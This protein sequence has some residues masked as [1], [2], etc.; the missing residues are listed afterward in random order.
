MKRISLMFCVLFISLCVIVTG[1]GKK[2]V[3]PQIFESKLESYNYAVNKV[4]G[5]ETTNS[6]LQNALLAIPKNNDNIRVWYYIYKSKDNAIKAYN[7]KVESTNTYKDSS[8]ITSNEDSSMIS[9]YS[10]ESN[11]NYIL[12]TRIDN[13][14]ISVESDINMKDN[15]KS[16][17]E[18]L[19]Y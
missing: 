18:E 12:T 2:V 7:K 4:A 16:L 11:K 9:K 17:M 14:I 13:T 10:F 5:L 1:C 19:G 8:T 15:M 6:G 3:S